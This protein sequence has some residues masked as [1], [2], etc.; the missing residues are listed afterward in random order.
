M[1]TPG[2]LPDLCSDEIVQIRR[3][4]TYMMEQSAYIPAQQ[5]MFTAD[6]RGE[7]SEKVRG[8][9]EKFWSQIKDSGKID[10]ARA[11]YDEAERKARK[12]IDVNTIQHTDARE[13]GA[14]NVCLQAIREL[15]LDTFLRREGWSERKINSTLA[16]LIIRTVY[17][18]SE[19]AA[20]R[21]LDENSAAMELLTG[22]FGD[23]P[24]QREV[25][26][27]APSL[28]AL[29]DKLERHLCSRTDSLFNLTNRVMLFDLTNFYFEGSK[30]GSKKAKFGR[31]KEKRSDCRLLVLAL[32]INTEGFIR[33]SSILAGNTADPDSL[34]AMVEDIIS[35]NPV[36]T[37]S[38]Q[39]VMV[40]IDAGIA[41][42][43]NL[44][45][46]KERGYNYLC[47]SRTKL[48]DYTL[49]EEGR[50]VTVLDSHKRPITIAQV[51]HREG[52]DFYLRITSPAKAMTEHSMNQQWRE[53]F[54]LEL[55]KARNAL[56]AKGGTKRYDKV[57][58]RVGRALGKYPSVSKYYQIDYIRSDKNPEQMSD[59]HWQIKISQ[60]K[61][62]QRFGTY[63]LR[64]N[65]ATLDERSAWDYYNLIRE[66]ETSNRQLK[67]DLE[68][69]PI[70]HQ[71]DD[72]SD[73][74]LFFGLLS[75]WI[76]NTVRHKLKLQGITHYW[77]EL[78]RILSTQKAI[79][80][81]AENALGEQIELRI[82]SDP[83][84]AASELYRT[85]GY[86]PI[87]FRRHTI[88]TAPPPP[89]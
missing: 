18:P 39:K 80:T 82:C 75:Y 58:E 81:K 54:E 57:V 85:L 64:T 45:L 36:S 24:T 8:Y 88:K 5:A 27:A 79:T 40:V 78:K 33:Y 12:L 63:F 37:N 71:T 10:S 3:G 74:H 1:L 72:N 7:Y 86:N 31:S 28:Y 65:V 61:A 19:W 14:E 4:L 34:P 60:D 48:K 22:Q 44:G 51:E 70:Y 16:S 52:G 9:I 23:C 25:Y 17:S 11:S 41:T 67:T 83:T 38:Q 47:V 21:I 20:L 15:Q 26:A 55:T 35:K 62:E 73:A 42:E 29:K 76:V 53:R 30:T 59:I 32:A 66:I 46:L 89:N 6:P 13:A 87:P 77:A 56:T 69:R 49:K 43:A 84:D 68:L 2:Y 50:S